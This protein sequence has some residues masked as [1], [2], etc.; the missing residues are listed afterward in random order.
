MSTPV[1]LQSILLLQRNV[2]RAAKYYSEGLGLRLKTVTNTWA[3]LD[4][5]G[6]NVLLKHSDGCVSHAYSL[7]ASDH[8]AMCF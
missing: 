1:V 4:G 6:V 8:N 7:S 5:G 2:P 3:D